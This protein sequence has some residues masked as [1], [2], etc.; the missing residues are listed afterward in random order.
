[1]HLSRNLLLAALT[2]LPPA[3]R[4]EE[5]TPAPDPTPPLE[6]AYGGRVLPPMTAPNKP[7]TADS[8]AA[9]TSAPREWD[10]AL[11][12]FAQ[13]V[14]DK[15]YDL[16][17]PYFV[18]TSLYISRE[19]RRLSSLRVGF[20]GAPLENLDFVQFPR[21]EIDNQSAQMLA[22]AF[23]LPFLSAYVILGHT[24]GTG[25]IDIAIGGQGLMDYLGIPGCQLPPA[26]RPQLCGQTLTPVAHANYTGESAGVGFTLAGAWHDLFFAMPVTYVVAQVT[27]SD[28]PS[29]TWNVAPR[30]GWNQHLQGGGML[31]WYAG[32]T[33]LKSD[34]DITGTLQLGT[35][36][37]VIDRPTSMRYSIHVQPLDP[38]NWLAGA[39]WTI[40][41]SWSI[42][43]EL[44]F[45]GARSNVLLTGFYRF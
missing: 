10:R 19:A 11:P 16:P 22:G 33:W 5:P 20:D 26:L 28:T 36:D 37:T 43:G 18:G 41:K 8:S 44:G 12:F 45:G 40:N 17:N 9:D 30:A 42:A 13:R 23:I 4:A 35:E 27:Q 14:I 38:W 21:T 7:A 39:N 31:T 32:A 15:G 2:M 3:P 1:M 25:D 34:F 6:L 29:K 24:Q